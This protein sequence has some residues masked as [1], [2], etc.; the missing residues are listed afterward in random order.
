MKLESRKIP[1]HDPTDPELEQA[2]NDLSMEKSKLDPWVVI[3]V[4]GALA[5]AALTGLRV[6]SDARPAQQSDKRKLRDDGYTTSPSAS[7][8]PSMSYVPSTSYSPSNIPSTSNFPSASSQPSF[9]KM[10]AVDC[11]AET[12]DDAIVPKTIILLTVSKSSSL[13]MLILLKEDGS[14]VPVARSYRGNDW[15]PYGGL[16]ASLSVDCYG[17][18]QC[19]I[20]LEPPPSGAT[21]VLKSTS[22][23]HAI[24]IE[25]KV[26]RFLESATFGGSPAEID[27]LAKTIASYEMDETTAIDRAFA[28]WVANQQDSTTTPL[29]SHRAFFRQRTLSWSLGST[30]TTL[31]TQPCAMGSRYRRYSFTGSDYEQLLTIGNDGNGT[32]P[33]FVNGLVRTV[34]EAPIVFS[35]GSVAEGGKNYELCSR[36]MKGLGATVK[37]RQAG[38]CRKVVSFGSFNGNPPIDFFDTTPPE[39]FD[40]T[41]YADAIDQK[42]YRYYEEGS[43]QMLNVTSTIPPEHCSYS[44]APGLQEHFFVRFGSEW[45]ISDTR[46]VLLNNDIDTPLE[47]GGQSMVSATSEAAKRDW[48]VRCSNVPRTYQN[49]DR[50]F[51]NEDRTCAAG[52]KFL[53]GGLVCGSPNEVSTSRSGGGVNGDGQFN[54]HTKF[55]NAGDAQ[56]ELKQHIWTA[57]VLSAK[58]QLRQRV[59]WALSQILV[60]GGTVLQ[61]THT[62]QHL[63]YYDIFV[64]HAFGSFRDV[65][66]DVS[67]SPMMAKYLDYYQSKSTGYIWQ[68]SK[69][70]EYPD[71]NYA[72]EVMQLFSIGL[73]K[74][75]QDGTVQRNSDGSL[76]LAYTNDDIIEF[77]RVWTGFNGQDL[78]GNIEEK[79]ELNGVDP[80]R[81]DAQ[82]RDHFPKMGLNGQYIG[83]G[84]PLCADLPSEHFLKKGAVYRL[85]GRTSQS[86]LQ[87]D[88]ESESWRD[89]GEAVQFMVDAESELHA[90]LCKEVDGYCTFP[91]V[92]TLDHDLESCT[93]LECQVDTVRTVELVNGFNYEYVRRPCVHQAF[94]EDAKIIKSRKRR[95]RIPRFMCANPGV[96]DAQAACCKN[97]RPERA[98]REQ[99]YFGERVVFETAKARCAARD[100]FEMCIEPDS[101]NVRDCELGAC[102][103]DGFYWADLAEGC[104]LQAKIREDGR[105]AVV[106][107]QTSQENLSTVVDHVGE[108]TKSFFVV[109]WNDRSGLS[110]LLGNCGTPE[111]IC[112]KTEDESC[113]CPVEVVSK[114]AF[115]AS[116]LP[117]SSTEVLDLP[118][119]AIGVPALE[120]KNGSVTVHTSGTV[121]IDA[122]F[123]VTDHTGKTCYRKNL[124]STVFIRTTALSFLNP[125]HTISVAE[126]NVRDVLAE[127]EEAINQL[128]HNTNTAPFIAIRMA[129]RFGV[130]NPSPRY[131]NEIATAFRMGRYSFAGESYGSGK[132]GNLGATIAAVLLDSEARDSLLD[133]DPYHGAVR[134]P[135][136]K[137]LH[138][139]RALDFKA[140]PAAPYPI[141][142]NMAS[143]IKQMAHAIPNVFSFFKPEFE[144]DGVIASSSLVSPEAAAHNTPEIIN[145]CNGLI[146][147]IKYGLVNCADN[148]G[149]TL[150]GHKSRCSGR[151]RGRFKDGSSGHLTFSM[152]EGDADS[153]VNKLAT[154]LTSGRLNQH[155]RGIIKDSYLNAGP[156]EGPVKAQ[157]L[158]VTTAEFHTTG[159]TTKDGDDRPTLSLPPATAR[160]YKATIFV[161]LAGGIDSFNIVTPHTCDNNLVDQYE[162]ERRSVMLSREEREKHVIDAE[163]QPCTKFSVHPDFN[164][165]A[166]L[167]EEGELAFYM[168]TGVLDSNET[169]KENYR[170]VTPTG[171]FAHNL[172][173]VR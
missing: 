140:D 11:P 25:D 29:T 27:S 21:Y 61:P 102:E 162:R 80:M 18:Y 52:Q 117:T 69:D 92:V 72:R 31:T 93:G 116:S 122:V 149:T 159:T 151:K 124:L 85:M 49:E 95:N 7:Q 163:G 43:I 110:E 10:L 99:S 74:L 108:D 59:A 139:M 3:L 112:T 22:P 120:F 156:E 104:T 143:R 71:E 171:L 40:I 153:V 13:C 35:D 105:V 88:Q 173:Q 126:P 100:R 91:A 6:I 119:A 37:L 144:A 76:A 24:T 65:L 58:D 36:G 20:P 81:F 79:G 44:F 111:S 60:I 42:S 130:S 114:P 137:V 15:E 125:I 136:I 63:A 142:K 34:V 115:E 97:S 89:N 82:W 14:R 46:F 48:K 5:L 103:N 16:Y 55:D 107:S 172:M 23:A 62:E 51:W 33:L 152:P 84:L 134:E 158:I 73:Y 129:Q 38:S 17:N 160:G 90:A 169:T 135:L 32:L 54:V 123:Q 56:K 154:L 98:W 87:R 75:N 94:Y 170:E 101:L 66:K 39:W 128:F 157:E 45:F 41:P 4:V 68:K 150:A 138:V 19:D 133:A 147:L 30:R 164:F 67:L 77:A 155:S 86:D 148:F 50:C 1:G 146:S 167:Y 141:L 109:N 118:Y 113:L 127:T 165:V 2:K 131:V 57:S 106:H 70:L 28:S 121:D 8:A 26:A 166:K 168:N 83:H 9:P 12:D 161:M 145:L 96:D 53:S 47:D 78:R 64:R 132:Y